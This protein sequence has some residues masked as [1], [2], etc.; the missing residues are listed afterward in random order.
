LILG[1]VG[2]LEIFQK[3]IGFGVPVKN[4]RVA[5]RIAKAAGKRRLGSWRTSLVVSVED[6]G[7][8]PTYCITEP[9]TNTVTVNGIVTGQCRHSLV[10][11]MPGYGFKNGSL[12]YIE[13][14]YNIIV[15]QR[16]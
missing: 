1:G 7:V 16:K 11:I 5:D 4:E 9:M 6:I 8:Q 10:S 14:G 12:S 2:N 3:E 13:P 15:D